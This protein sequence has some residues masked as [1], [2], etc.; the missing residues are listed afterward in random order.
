[1]EFLNLPH[2]KGNVKQNLEGY[3]THNAN[4]SFNDTGH[5]KYYRSVENHHWKSD[6]RE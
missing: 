1:M 2:P 5:D 6:I 3:E 4:N